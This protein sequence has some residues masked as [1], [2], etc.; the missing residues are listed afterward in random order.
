MRRTVLSGALSPTPATLDAGLGRFADL[1]QSPKSM[2]IADLQAALDNTRQELESRNLLLIR[3]KQ[4]LSTLGERLTVAAT[5]VQHLEADKCR[6]EAELDDSR[7]VLHDNQTT[8]DA[9]V[10]NLREHLSTVRSQCA[11]DITTAREAFA[12]REHEWQTELA[13]SK[14]TTAELQDRVAAMTTAEQGWTEELMQAQDNIENLVEQ[15]SLVEEQLTLSNATAT[16][17]FK[18]LNQV[19]QQMALE[20]Q[21]R[22]ELAARVSTTEQEVVDRLQQKQHE[23]DSLRLKVTAQQKHLKSNKKGRHSSKS[24]SGRQGSV[25]VSENKENC[26]PVHKK[27][28]VKILKHGNRRLSNGGSCGKR[29]PTSRKRTPSKEERLLHIL[30]TTPTSGG[31]RAKRKLMKKKK[32]GKRNGR[33]SLGSMR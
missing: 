21:Q 23:V 25:V 29:T 8:H 30:N 15:M 27:M 2:Q 10:T 5:T 12:Q 11:I 1:P 3:S 32:G 16:L 20:Q 24:N 22:Q 6:L 13:T 18:E 26:M 28:T 17:H 9:T 14:H 7:T 19:K 31:G 4:A 33:T